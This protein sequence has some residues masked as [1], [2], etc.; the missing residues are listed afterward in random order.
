M[1]SPGGCRI[2]CPPP[3]VDAGP[4]SGTAARIR[5]ILVFSSDGSLCL[6]TTLRAQ[7]SGALL[8]G[9]ARGG[10]ERVNLQRQVDVLCPGAVPADVARI[11]RAGKC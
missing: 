5:C 2:R 10:I 1:Q 4:E 6:L 9:P 8:L 7:P 11:G 3:S